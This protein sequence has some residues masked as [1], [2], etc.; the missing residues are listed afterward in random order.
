MKISHST[1]VPHLHTQLASQGSPPADKSFNIVSLQFS[2]SPAS[3]VSMKR[4]SSINNHMKKYLHEKR[5][6][7]INRKMKIRYIYE[8]RQEARCYYR[9]IFKV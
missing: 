1:C 7:Q 3:I 8:K 6:K 2:L 4:E 5:P 9:S